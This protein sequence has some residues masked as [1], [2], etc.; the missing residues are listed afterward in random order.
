MWSKIHF[1]FFI[2]LCITKIFEPCFM[3]RGLHT[4]CKK[5]KKKKK[6]STY[7][8]F[9]QCSPCR[10]TWAITF[11]YLGIFWM[12]RDH[13]TL[14][15]VN[16]WNGFLWIHNQVRLTWS[17]GSW[18]CMGTLYHKMQTFNNLEEGFFKTWWEKEKML[19]T[20]IFSFSHHVF[21]PSQNKFQFFSHIYFVIG[22]VIRPLQ[23]WWV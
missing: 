11:C 5:K 21:Y 22:E 10:L 13:S 14:W 6:V 18:R 17:H 23:Q 2:S 4:F 15:L 20:S 7:F 9:S 16:W 3:K 19:V 8:S 1:F 12:S